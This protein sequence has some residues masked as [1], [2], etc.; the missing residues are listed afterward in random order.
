MAQSRT[1]LIAVNHTSERQC[2][3]YLVSLGSEV[4]GKAVQDCTPES[5]ISCLLRR[6][7]VLALSTCFSV[8]RCPDMYPG[9][10]RAWQKE[11]IYAF[12]RFC[13]AELFLLIS[14][15]FSSYQGDYKALQTITVWAVWGWLPLFLYKCYH[16]T[17]LCSRHR[18]IDVFSEAWAASY[19]PTENGER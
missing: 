18:V 11:Q 7:V 16:L 13:A 19:V 14:I 5:I 17:Y 3:H 10:L 2:R 12:G 4:Q 6:R 9:M 1:H 15:F 8:P